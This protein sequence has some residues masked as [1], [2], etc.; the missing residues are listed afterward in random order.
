MKAFTLC[1]RARAP[2]S[3]LALGMALMT[4]VCLPAV[5][6]DE[7]A[8]LSATD[9]RLA[10]IR[11]VSQTAGWND[12]FSKLERSL[13]D[14]ALADKRIR[15]MSRPAYVEFGTFMR[16]R[17]NSKVLLESAQTDLAGALADVP[18]SSLSAYIEAIGQPLPQRM[19]ALDRMVN[20]QA[21]L[22][23]INRYKIG[24]QA[25]APPPERMALVDRYLAASGV[26]A[27]YM[28]DQIAELR[29]FLSTAEE[30][31][32]ESELDE[33]VR[34]LTPELEKRVEFNARADVLALYRD[35]SDT[36]LETYVKLLEAPAVAD[37]LPK[38][39]ATSVFAH[40]RATKD[41]LR[42]LAELVPPS[43]EDRAA[44]EAAQSGK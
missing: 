20:V 31:I 21:E 7:T 14:R 25:K 22:P 40:Q 42:K 8:T 38:V 24:L 15:R 26:K 16:D 39:T 44:V 4:G 1:T 6:A 41:M 3:G 19:L 10:L 36:D 43:A 18:S 28:S 27:A 34:I 11:E 35:V 12:A 9:A 30:G 29:Q 37:V 33:Q 32:A 17:M 23:H 2:L 13:R 5:A